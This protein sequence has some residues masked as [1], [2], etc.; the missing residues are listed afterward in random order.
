MG[1][2]AFAATT[3]ASAPA[4]PA[5][6]PLLVS[7][8]DRVLLQ[9]GFVPVEGALRLYACAVGSPAGNHY[10]YDLASGALLAVWR[11]DFLDLSQMWGPR[12]FDQTAQP[13]APAVTLSVRPLLALF[14]NRLLTFPQAWPDKPAP[15]Y[16]SRGYELESDG[17]P[18]FLAT[19]E[20]LHLRDRIA[21]SADGQGLTRRLEFSG[22]A[23]PWHTWL[24][25]GEADVIVERKNGR[26]WAAD[27]SWTIE[28]RAGAPHRPQVR[29]AGA[30][31][32]LVVRLEKDH[33][34]QPVV[35]TVRW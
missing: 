4:R 28:W 22:R 31:Q 6:S 26:E 11:G 18:V 24:L 7:P 29:A 10:A 1:V 19:F 15:L 30:R 2:G 5:A 16:A 23:S 21:S 13:A 34:S 25:L 9:R 12:A 27:G 35:Y 3:P 20:E 32:Q 14:P 8:Q 33:L 17:Q